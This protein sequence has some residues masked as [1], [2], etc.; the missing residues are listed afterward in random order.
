MAKHGMYTNLTTV[1]CHEI[2]NIHLGSTRLVGGEAEL[3]W[4]F[5]ATR[6]HFLFTEYRHNA[7]VR[8]W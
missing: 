5:N 2:N 4:M 7:H 1:Y 8:S 3:D 6:S